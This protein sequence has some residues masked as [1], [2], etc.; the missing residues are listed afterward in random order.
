[1]RAHSAALIPGK[2]TRHRDSV[3]VGKVGCRGLGSRCAV[4]G[5][6][7][8]EIR[9]RKFRLAGAVLGSFELG[10]VAGEKS[11]GGSWKVGIFA[12]PGAGGG[13]CAGTRVGD[14]STS[15]N[16]QKSR[17]DERAH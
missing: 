15:A 17:P 3:V 2:R 14:A 8:P 13:A 9:H 10:V 6:V 4:T 7:L 11:T 16:S 12:A 1:M 5:R